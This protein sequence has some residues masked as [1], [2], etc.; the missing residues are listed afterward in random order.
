MNEQT[1]TSAKVFDLAAERIKR[2]P[3]T[4]NVGGGK[5]FFDRFLG[6][7]FS[8]SSAPP[9][10]RVASTPDDVMRPNGLF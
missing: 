3:K 8:R 10:N 4:D 9:K 2:Q 5:S 7:V 6:T 1:Q